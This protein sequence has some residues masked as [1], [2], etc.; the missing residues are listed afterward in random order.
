M[1]QPRVLKL[2]KDLP[3]LVY[4]LNEVAKTDAGPTTTEAEQRDYVAMFETYGQVKQWIMEHHEKPQEA[5]AHAWFYKQTGTPYA[6]FT[7]KIHPDAR[8]LELEKT[9]LEIVANEAKTQQASYL[10]A[11]IDSKNSYLHNVLLAQG[12]KLERGYHA[13][14][15]PLTHSF[16][17]AQLTGFDLRTY[18]QV[19]D[20]NIILKIMD[21]GLGD[22]PGHKKANYENTSWVDQQA[23]DS[24]FLLF[25]KKG[26][27][28]GT[29][30]TLPL[31]DNLARIDAG[32]LV[33]EYRTPDLYRQ[34][35]LVALNYAVEKGCKKAKLESWGDCEST[36]DVYKSLGF[37]ITVHELGYRFDLI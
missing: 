15:M 19:N 30:G 1:V 25:D 7:L 35:A 21:E 20:R 11:L 12:F 5:I 2:D 8:G 26:Q 18:D 29:T 33:P 24:I 4:L 14:E 10:Y 34:L 28:I 22:L 37:E 36:I 27:V 23:R 13:M 6:E 32:G 3:A 31:E 16:P 17:K 9:M